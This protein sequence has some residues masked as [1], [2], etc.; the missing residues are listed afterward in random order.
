MAI[1]CINFVIHFKTIKHLNYLSYNEAKQ[2][3][4]KNL[5]I[6]LVD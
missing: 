4:D 6:E 2:K 1:A 3:Q 5:M